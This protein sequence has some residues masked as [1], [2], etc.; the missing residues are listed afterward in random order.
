MVKSKVRKKMQNKDQVVV[1]K[2]VKITK[3]FNKLV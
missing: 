2:K 1:V 3:P